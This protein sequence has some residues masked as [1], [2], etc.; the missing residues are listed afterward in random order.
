MSLNTMKI[1]NGE[2]TTSLLFIKKPLYVLQGFCN[3]SQNA[4]STRL[5]A[6]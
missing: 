2:P 1:N 6:V 3:L 4:D 5:L